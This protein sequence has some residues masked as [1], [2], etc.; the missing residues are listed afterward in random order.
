MEKLQAALAYIRKKTDF[1]P[2]VAV[3][4][5]SGL[6]GFAAR[7]DAVTAIEYATIPHFPK[8]T[9]SGHRGR[10]VFGYVGKT[11]VVLMEGRVHY[12]EGYTM[13]EVVMPIRLMRLLGA[14][15]LL[16]TN[17]AGGINESFS[18]CDFML[19][20][21]HISSFVPSPLLGRNQEVLGTRFP[22]MSAVYDRDLQNVIRAAAQD[23]K[24]PLRE[25]VYVQASGPQYETP[26]EIR[27]FRAL[28]ADAVGMSTAC[29]AI[30]ARHAGMRVGGISCISN[31]AAGVGDTPLSHE[32]VKKTADKV[33]TD[34]AALLNLVLERL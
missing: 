30:A 33:E 24:I 18:P 28:G 15:T 19:I 25:G 7:T 13:E 5:G 16:L 12:Y 22:D 26:A 11:P 8:S 9:V 20:C 23:A 3:V 31:M 29:E 14:E 27:A 10:F 1:K 2:R 21:D 4:L 6:G 17:A 32:D 34:F